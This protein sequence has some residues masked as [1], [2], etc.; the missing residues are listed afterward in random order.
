[1]N[2]AMRIT[3]ETFV[4]TLL[5]LAV[6][7]LLTA[8]R[9]GTAPRQI[10][11]SPVAPS[12]PFGIAMLGILLAIV[13]LVGIAVILSDIARRHEEQAL[14]LQAHV[15][16]ALSDRPHL[17]LLPLAAT[18]HVPLWRPAAAIITLTGRVPTPKLRE[19][20][21][22]TVFDKIWATWPSAQIENRIV[23]EPDRMRHATAQTREQ[24]V[25]R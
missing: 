15:S 17:A 8:Q 2:R 25:S 5:L 23:V 7:T 22:Q 10:A 18:V 3:S 20:V 4:L 6:P 16:S 21:V 13:G 19:T 12:G 14:Y 11:T 1:M 24:V 9:L